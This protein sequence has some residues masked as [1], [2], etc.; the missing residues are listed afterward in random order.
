MHRVV[1][2][3][4]MKGSRQPSMLALARD[5]I[6]EHYLQRPWLQNIRDALARN[7]QQP[8]PKRTPVRTQ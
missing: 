5:Y 2:D 3:G 6:V 7:R 4:A 8:E 1:P